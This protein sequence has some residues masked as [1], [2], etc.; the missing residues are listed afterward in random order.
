MGI[1]SLGLVIALVA[2]ALFFANDKQPTWLALFSLVVYVAAFSL[3]LG[4]IPWLVMSEIFPG[5]SV[6]GNVSTT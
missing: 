5:E 4:P 3:G 6:T 1:S 2:L